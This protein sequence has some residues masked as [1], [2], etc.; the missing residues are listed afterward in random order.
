M[1]FG[2]VHEWVSGN[3]CLLQHKL[4][5][6]ALE[7]RCWAPR[8]EGRLSWTWSPPNFLHL[9]TNRT[10]NLH[11]IIMLLHQR[12]TNKI[13][14]TCNS[15]TLCLTSMKVEV[16]SGDYSTTKV[17]TSFLKVIKTNFTSWGCFINEQHMNILYMQRHN[18]M[19]IIDEAGTRILWPQ[20]SDLLSKVSTN[21]TTSWWC[22]INE[23]QKNLTFIIN[24]GGSR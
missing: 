22:Y 21:F 13:S 5:A 3:S 14:Y 7:G 9:P 17:M 11:N 8:I 16:E 18:L 24:E 20:G 12:A 4:Y 2:T 23:N 10:F 1:I 19:V 6:L 15:K